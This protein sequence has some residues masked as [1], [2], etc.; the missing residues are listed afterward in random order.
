M[1]HVTNHRL[2]GI[3]SFQFPANTAGH[4]TFLAGLEHFHIVHAMTAI[5]QININITPLRTLPG[6][7]LDL[8]QCSTERMAIMWI[9]RQ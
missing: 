7:A 3:S 5:S 4:A 9:A 6:Q 1:L 8:S 2:N